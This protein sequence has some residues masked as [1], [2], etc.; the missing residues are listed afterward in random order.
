MPT[1]DEER[2]AA[3]KAQLIQVDA[4]IAVVLGG[5]MSYSLDSGQTRQSVTR[6]SLSE[7]RAMQAYLEQKVKQLD[8]AVNGGG[9]ST[10]Y[11]R[12][13]F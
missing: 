10:V 11:V 12:P 7:L 8:G 2:L 13:G 1:F 9:G 6:S 4:A 5:G 3:A